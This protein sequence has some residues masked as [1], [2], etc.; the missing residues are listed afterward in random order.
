MKVGSIKRSSAWLLVMGGFVA[1]SHVGCDD[2]GG[3][4][5]GTSSAA[6]SSC[7]QAFTADDCKRWGDL[8]GCEG[9]V[10]TD[11]GTC[12]AGIAGCSFT[13]CNGAPIC[14]DEGTGT[15]ATCEGDL[16]QAECETIGDAAGCS[17][18]TTSMVNACGKDAVACDFTGCDFTPS[19]D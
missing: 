18:A 10:V 17:S 8:A 11:E 6:C 5:G 9:A 13:N 15:C 1:G 2:G 3:G 19:C 7:Q 4:G 12:Q 14:N 16:S